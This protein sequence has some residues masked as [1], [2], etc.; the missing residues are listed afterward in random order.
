MKKLF[1]KTDKN[2]EI[3]E[4]KVKKPNKIK[5]ISNKFKLKILNGFQALSKIIDKEDQNF[6]FSLSTYTLGYGALINFAL[7]S[8]FGV[9][10]SWIS[11][12]GYGLLLWLIDNKFIKLIRRLYST[13]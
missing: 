8:I 13:R 12:I 7:Y 10:F 11:F 1:K 9:P 4:K 3:P 6:I 2:E 5:L